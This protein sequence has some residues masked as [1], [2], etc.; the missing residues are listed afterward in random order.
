[1]KERWFEILRY[2]I[3]GGL[4]TVV[5]LAVY[6]GLVF[7]VLDPEKALE[8]QAANIISWVAAV[9]FAYVTNRIFVFRSRSAKILKELSAFVSAR[10]ATL[11]MD[12]VIMFAGVTI[13]GWN[14]KL[15]KLFIVQPLMIIGNYL[16]SKF[17]VFRKE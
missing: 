12:M 10:V 5:A 3:V 16:F 1:M 4:T 7:T 2:L 8:L 11:I 9:A 14:D 13:L 15:V 6:Y 17:I